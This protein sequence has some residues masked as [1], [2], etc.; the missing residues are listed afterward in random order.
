MSDWTRVGHK[1]EIGDQECIVVD[2]DDVL[3]AVFNLAGE[4]F[5]LED[6]CTHD[7]AEI[8][9][10]CIENGCII[11]PRHGAE[12][13][14]RTGQVVNGPAWEPVEIFPVRIEDNIVLVRDPRWD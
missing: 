6:V 14:I 12:F 5:A 8:A 9:T 3:I 13:D 4:F 2:V 11:C 7:G 1:D 10:G